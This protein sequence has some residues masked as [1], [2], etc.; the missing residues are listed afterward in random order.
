MATEYKL[1][2]TGAEI[3]EKLGR[4][5]NKTIA[6]EEQINKFGGTVEITSGE[7]AKENTVLTLDPNGNEVNIYTAEEVDFM[8]SQMS[9]G[10][11]M[12][13]KTSDLE[14]DSGFISSIPSEYVTETELNAKGYLTSVPSEY[15][16]ETELSAK[17]YLTSHQDISGKADKAT[18]LAGYGITDGATKTELSSLSEEI[19]N[20]LSTEDKVKYIVP[21][22][23]AS[24]YMST[25]GTVVSQSEKYAYTERLSV[26]EGQTIRGVVNSTS[27]A[28]R[29]MYIA[30][31][32][33]TAYVDGVAKSSLGVNG[34]GASITEYIVPENVTEVVVSAP[35]YNSAYSNP[36]IEIT[37]PATNSVVSLGYV[38]N[39]YSFSLPKTF[40]MRNGETANIYLRNLTSPNY[41]VRLGNYTDSTT[42]RNTDERCEITANAVA[43]KPIS[44]VVYDE[45]CNVIEDGTM[46]LS[47]LGTA[48]ASQKMLCLGDSFVAMAEIESALRNLF[49]ADGKTLTLIGTKGSGSNLHEGYGG[50][51]CTDFANGFSG[52]PFGESGFDFASYMSAQGYS[53]LNSVYIQLGTNDVSPTNPNQDLASVVD[54]MKTI[55]TSVQSYDST[56]K[57]YVGLTVMPNLD[58][59]VF[60][61]TYNG[62]GWNWILKQNMLRLNELIIN[63]YKDS[64]VKVVATNCVLDNTEDIRD[65]VHPTT[66]GFGKMAKQLYNTM[67]A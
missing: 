40:Y 37:T 48:P 24:A 11:N 41:K 67:M 38:R 5:P 50:K 34:V 17:G 14:N 53:G 18:T 63:E 47:I 30:F 29:D 7:P 56:I 44:Y 20:L 4:I 62:T 57:I 64:N 46:T 61:E 12:P 43:N 35:F 65:N 55:V 58:S 6:T 1:S 45:H 66:E 27:N 3:N 31:T 16:T 19:D 23:T 9:G 21:T 2:Y 10:V 52:S 22:L 36:R 59:E 32:T 33:I 49:T 42:I 28:G 15:V 13:T 26:K 60:A 8:M 54:A 25:S 51:K 39:D